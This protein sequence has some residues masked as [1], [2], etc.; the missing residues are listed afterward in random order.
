MQ[1]LRTLHA[2]DGLTRTA[3]HRLLLVDLVLH[4]LDLGKLRE[5]AEVEDDPLLVPVLAAA[6]VDLPF[7]GAAKFTG[8]GAAG[9][10]AGAGGCSCAPA[11]HPVSASADKATEPRTTAS[12]LRTDMECESPC[13][14][15]IICVFASSDAPRAEWFP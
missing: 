5:S 4:E 6:D 12:V 3:P 1:E 11:E 14:S 7:F 9:A 15:L 10:A 2:V 13:A 8:A